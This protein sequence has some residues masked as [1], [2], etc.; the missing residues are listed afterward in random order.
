[1]K[2]AC[3]AVLALLLCCVLQFGAFGL[4]SVEVSTVVPGEHEI[5]VT[6]NEGGYVLYGGEVL[7]SGTT[8]TV[9]RF[10][11][12]TLSV[13]CQ[14][15][16][17]LQSVTVNGED[18]TDQ[19]QYGQLI[20]SG[21]HTNV[22]IVFTFQKCEDAKPLDPS[23]PEYDPED[24]NKGADECVHYALSGGVYRGDKPYPNA[25]LVFDFGEI[26]TA[27][28]EDGE[29]AVDDIK[30]GYHTVTVYDPDGTVA[31]TANFSVTESE[32]ATEVTVTK[33]PDGTQLVTVPTG[34]ESILLDFVVN[35]GADGKPDGTVTI[36]VGE[37]PEVPDTTP[38]VIVQT[39]ALIREYP[40]A[41]GATLVL[42]FGGIPF[43]FFLLRRKKKQQEEENSAV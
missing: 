43:L 12:V 11:D 33:L 31:G 26:E 25:G 34:T 38:P 2:K 4:G 21:V 32:T 41:A 9:E 20:L 19:M 16:D 39:G 7:P 13:I 27:A 6:Y 28:N 30:D 3:S 10:D 23:D 24:P 42:L 18:V 37:E 14:A 1:M 36:K 35:L 8:L 17:H 40:V 5:T 15:T 22:D 29:Y